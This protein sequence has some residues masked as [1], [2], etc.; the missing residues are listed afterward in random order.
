M[1]CKLAHQYCNQWTSAE[2]FFS[3]M[4]ALAVHLSVCSYHFKL[5]MSTAQ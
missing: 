4:Q 2:K 3:V 5:L 1:V